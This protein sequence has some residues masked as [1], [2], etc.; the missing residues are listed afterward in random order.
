MRYFG[1]FVL[2]LAL[3]LTMFCGG[4][5]QAQTTERSSFVNSSKTQAGAR[6]Q[7]PGCDCGCEQTGKCICADKSKT[8]VFI[9]VH[10]GPCCRRRQAPPPPTPVP[11]P[12]TDPALISAFQRM[13]DQQAQLIAMLAA[14]QTSPP[15]VTPQNG[16][17]HIFIIPHNGQPILLP[18]VSGLPLLTPPVSGDP[19]LTPPVSGD[20]R[21]AP[22][23][24]GPPKLTPPAGGDPK[25][26][27]PV[28]SGDPKLAPTGEV[29]SPPSGLMRFTRTNKVRP[30]Y[31]PKEIK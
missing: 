25:L 28:G 4:M 29:S 31:R 8:G 30:L 18:P 26:T 12:V 9:G 7:C 10:I 20:P 24:G 16:G 6:V 5:L 22:P 2:A 13:M 27:P 11:L 14:R 23:V 1:V 19:R 17:S 3:L 15:S 21:L